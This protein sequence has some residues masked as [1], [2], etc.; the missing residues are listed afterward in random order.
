MNLSSL[1]LSV[2]VVAGVDLNSTFQDMI[3][4]S[5]KLECQI[6][7]EVNDIKVLAWPEATVEI[8]K[9]RWKHQQQTTKIIT[10]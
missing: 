3:F 7:A 6:E 4:L 2:E 8:L 1:I 9:E 5:R 10:K